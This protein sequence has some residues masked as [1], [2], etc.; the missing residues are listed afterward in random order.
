MRC[1]FN[2]AIVASQDL[3]RTNEQ[4]KIDIS[5][6]NQIYD[7]VK[8]QEAT[9]IENNKQLK[10]ELSEKVK[11]INE[12]EE[13]RAENRERVIKLESNLSSLNETVKQLTAQE[14]EARNQY[15]LSS[16]RDKE[17]ILQLE[18][19]VMDLMDENGTLRKE[20][21]LNNETWMTKE[22]DSKVKELKSIIAKMKK[23]RDILQEDNAQQLESLQTAATLEMNNGLEKLQEE[24]DQEREELLLQVIS[25]ETS[26]NKEKNRRLV[27]NDNG[28]IYS[29]FQSFTYIH[30][31]V[32]VYVTS[33]TCI[34][35]CIF[36]TLL[37]YF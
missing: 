24:N 16:E 35:T 23:D 9:L 30:V 32:Y 21:Y 15:E 26:L 19:E 25:L 36:H 7:N 27:I 18:R 31:H 1:Q 2:E 20:V 13:E 12:M 33:P 29:T 4:L 28:S 8:L 34:Y 17:K 14:K 6:K 5:T 10:K 22:D 3:K 11:N 37:F